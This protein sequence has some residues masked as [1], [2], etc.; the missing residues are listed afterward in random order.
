MA[1]VVPADAAV[2][3]CLAFVADL[4]ALRSWNA[5]S[6][7]GE[8]LF[9]PSGEVGC[10]DLTNLQGTGVQTVD[11]QLFRGVYGCKAQQTCDKNGEHPHQGLSCSQGRRVNRADA[12]LL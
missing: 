12:R 2:P 9:A 8:D 3:A 6:G 1:V 10:C 5:A 7:R 4:A 11:W